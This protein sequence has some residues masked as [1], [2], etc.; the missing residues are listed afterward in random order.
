M[1]KF[2]IAIRTFSG[3]PG[4]QGNPPTNETEYNALFGA[5]NPWAT[6]PTWVQ[7]QAQIGDTIKSDTKDE[8]KK[9]IAITDWSVLP[10]VG[11]A[12]VAAFEAYRAALRELIKNPV[13]DPV[14]PI[15]PEPVWS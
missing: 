6:K 3:F 2:D 15:E 1:N 4:Y 8:A 11:L 9:R 5:D 12:N 10:D 7:V 13:A 14:W